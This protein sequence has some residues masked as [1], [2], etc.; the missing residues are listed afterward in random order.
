MP[1]LL[2]ALSICID[3]DNYRHNRGNNDYFFFLLFTI[4]FNSKN[5][6]SHAVAVGGGAITID[7][8][9]HIQIYS[10]DTNIKQRDKERQL[11]LS[12][13]WG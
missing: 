13:Y 5:S 10:T 1:I 2:I 7:K 12:K 3:S 11:L 9:S 4:G 8:R 6:D